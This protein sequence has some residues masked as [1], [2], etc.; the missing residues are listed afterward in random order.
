MHLKSMLSEGSQMQKC[1][2]SRIPFTWTSVEKWQQGSEGVTKEKDEEAKIICMEDGGGRGQ[3]GHERS[4]EKLFS[5]GYILKMEPTELSEELNAGCVR[6]KRNQGWLCDLGS[7]QM[8][9]WNCC[10]LR[11]W[12]R[13]AE[14]VGKEGESQQ[15]VQFEMSTRCTN[16]DGRSGV[17]STGTIPG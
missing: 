14:K 1:T 16:E 6:K 17:E 9:R 7:K 11:W 8:E 13:W 12:S 10:S 4:D 5:S 3:H 15:T 2:C